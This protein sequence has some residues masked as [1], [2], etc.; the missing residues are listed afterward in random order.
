MEE[1]SEIKSLVLEI[2]KIGK[3]NLAIL[4]KIK[5]KN[6]HITNIRLN[7]RHHYRSCSH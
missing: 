6:E 7:R 4:T 3:E 5:R 2:K 1:I